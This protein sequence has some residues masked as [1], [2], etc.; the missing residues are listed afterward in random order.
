MAASLDG[1]WIQLRW[2]N[3]GK[4]GENHGNDGENSPDVITTQ[5]NVMQHTPRVAEGRL[6]MRAL[7]AKDAAF[8]RRLLVDSAVRHFLGGPTPDAQ[9]RATIAGYFATADQE[10]SWIVTQ[11]DLPCGMVTLS[12]HKDGDATELSYQFAPRVWGS[13]VAF[14]ACRRALQH[15]LG[16]M[17]LHSVIA[18]TQVANQRSIK[19]LSRLGFEERKRLTRFG[20][21]QVIYEVT[22]DGCL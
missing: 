22:R 19:L 5:R 3:C 10:P 20:A 7:H 14:W 17:R 13:G 2:L 18:E 15:A 4:T 8:L 11:D 16:P 1:H 6:S 21:I 12:P 9:V